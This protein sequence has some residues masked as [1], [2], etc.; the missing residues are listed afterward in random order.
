MNME[1]ENN[2]LRKAGTR[3]PFKVPE[4]YFEGFT[5]ELMDRLPEKEMIPEMQEPTL[6]QRVKPWIYMTAMFCGIMLSVRIFVGEPQQEKF[7]ISQAEA[8][9]LPEEEW[10]NMIRRTLVDDYAIY[11]YL[12]EANYN[13]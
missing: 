8:E 11:E 3:N 9:M 12:T 10:E 1:K 4:G 7:P 5:Q 6:W 2:I 13:H